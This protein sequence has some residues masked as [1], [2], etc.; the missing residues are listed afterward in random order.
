M[1][2]APGQGLEVWVALAE[3]GLSSEVKRGENAGR[4]LSHAAVVRALATLP[5]PRPAEGGF[6]TEARLK[7]AP[8][9]KREKL[10][11][12][13]VLQAAGG[14]VSGVTAVALVSQ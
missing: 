11:A 14:P 7:L 1:E 3:D 9:W 8:G 12:V 13:A 5:A 4:R 2:A 10:R 6:V